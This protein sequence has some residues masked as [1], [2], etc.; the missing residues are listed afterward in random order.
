MSLRRDEKGVNHAKTLSLREV[1]GTWRGVPRRARAVLYFP[2]R[3]RLE[4]RTLDSQSRNRGSIP[5]TA[6]NSLVC[7]TDSFSNSNNGRRRR[8]PEPDELVWEAPINIVGAGL[9]PAPTA[10]ASAWVHRP[11]SSP[12]CGRCRC[13]G[14]V[15]RA[16]RA[17]PDG[18]GMRGDLGRSGI[19]RGGR[20]AGGF[21]S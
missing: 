3:Y 21:R 4:V 19:A 12:G 18:S 9:K 1:A 8:F 20:R 7:V 13:I 10:F 14:G 17:L 2:W 11:G 15:H 5:R 16:R 6:T